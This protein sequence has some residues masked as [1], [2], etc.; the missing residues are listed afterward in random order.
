MSKKTKNIIIETIVVTAYS[1]LYM[2]FS[3][4]LVLSN[5]S[6]GNVLVAIGICVLL[7]PTISGVDIL[8]RKFLLKDDD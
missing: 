2:M 5:A 3:V 1:I 6:N 4:M 8:L 7:S